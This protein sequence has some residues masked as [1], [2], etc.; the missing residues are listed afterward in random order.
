MIERLGAVLQR[1][2]SRVMPDPFVLA[3]V[4]TALVALL[5]LASGG[6]SGGDEGPLWTLALAWFAEFSS[7]GLMAFALKMALILVTGHALAL[8]APVQK[9]VDVVARVPR[10]GAQAAALVAFVAV[11]ASFLHWGLGAIVGALVAREIGRSAAQRGVKLHYPLLGAA[12]YA[13]FAVWHGGLSGSAPVTVAAEGHFLSDVMAAQVEGGVLP[14]SQTLFGSMNLIVGASLVVLIPLLCAW[15]T[16][17]DE[18]DFV[19]PDPTQIRPLPELDA[20]SGDTTLDR[21]QRSPI[22]GWV[23]GGGGLALVVTAI[24]T[25]RATFDLN[26]VVLSFLFLGV[27]LQGSLVRYAAAIADGARG[28]GAILLQFPFY[29][30]ILGLMKAGGLIPRISDAL[31][32][33]SSAETFPVLAF[34]SAGLVNLVV[35]SGGGQWV[36]QGD[37]LMSA[38]ASLSVDPATTVMAFSYG[39]AWSNLLQ[40]FWALPLLGIMGLRARDIIG[41][42]AVVFVAIGVVVPFWLLVLG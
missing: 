20:A 29:F 25:G 5:A 6:A 32:S 34:L 15:M 12:G 11:V 10:T 4:L 39:D 17:S 19:A 35:P 38:G 27:L 3:V 1:V 14:L 8:S 42:T 18:A 21:L 33:L 26:T 7:A 24:A 2:V 41:Y 40:P 13:G 36:V 22:G 9:G 31:V 37:I 16:P 28:A 23:L 30:G